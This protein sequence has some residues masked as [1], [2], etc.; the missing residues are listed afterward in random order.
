[1]FGQ[2]SFV[3]YGH[4]IAF[5]FSLLVWCLFLLKQN[6]AAKHGL[7][8]Q[9]PLFSLTLIPLIVAISVA[10]CLAYKSIFSNLPVRD[11]LTYYLNLLSNQG[12]LHT[13]PITVTLTSLIFVIKNVKP[14]NLPKSI[15]LNET[16]PIPFLMTFVAIFVGLVMLVSIEFLFAIGAVEL[17]RAFNLTSKIGY[18]TVYFYFQPVRQTISFFFYAVYTSISV[19][20]VLGDFGFKLTAS[21]DDPSNQEKL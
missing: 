6:L 19:T 18:D 10:F 16:L 12:H 9:Y 4:A 3:I 1:M 5:S 2:I 14:S 7:R 20:L 17:A 21:E 8:T 11:D 15:G 13:I